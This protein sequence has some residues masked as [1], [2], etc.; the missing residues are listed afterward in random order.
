MVNFYELLLLVVCLALSLTSVS[1][2][3]RARLIGWV[4]NVA[5]RPLPAWIVFCSTLLGSLTVA[6]LL[7]GPMPRINDEFSYLLMSDTFVS[8]RVANPS[9]PL[10][11]FFDTFHVLIRPVYASK[12][13]PVQGVFL[14][15][16]QKLTGHPAVGLWLS[17]ALACGAAFWMLRAW[18]GPMWGFLG[19]LIMVLQ[20]GVFSY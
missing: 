17:S 3:E 15:L 18:V 13:F 11:E 2:T 9:P 10:P 6:G 8:V 1:L 4:R 7:H 14:A 5:R 16:G 19:A 12:Y 20:F